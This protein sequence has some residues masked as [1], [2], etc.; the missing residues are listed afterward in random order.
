[1][2]QS[3]RLDSGTATATA[4]A[5]VAA[6]LEQLLGHPVAAWPGQGWTC[7]KQRTVRSVFRGDLDGV[8]VHIKL[9]RADKLSD[10]A[11][12]SLRGQ[13]GQ[14]EC[15]HLLQARA[16][17][18]PAAEPLAF[19]M[20]A[21]DEGLRSFVIT[22]TIADSAPFDFAM[23]AA[24]HDRVGRLLRRLHDLGAEASDLHPGNLLVD[25]HGQPWLID[26][27]AFRHSGEPK[28]SR[29]AHGLSIFCQHLDGGAIDRRARHLL[30][31]YRNGAQVPLPHQLEAQLEL[32]TRR[33]RADAL[34]AFG[35]RSTR[36]C[37]HTEVEPRRRG[38]PRWCWHLPGID[39]AVRDRCHQA[40]ASPPDATKSG[41]RGGVWQL[42]ELIMKRR[43]RGAAKKL[44]RAAYWLLFAGVDTARPVAMC[45]Q[46]GAGHVF[47]ARIDNVPLDRE[48]QQGAM[49]PTAITACARAL[50]RSIGRLHAHGL[51]NRDLKFDNL[52]RLPGSDRVAMVDLDG[53]RRKAAIDSRGSGADLGRLLAAFRQA[54]S[55]GGDATKRAFLRGWLRSHRDLLQR[56]PW[57]RVLRRAEQ[58][59]GE[60]FAS[61]R[62]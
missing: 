12:D 8:P 45:L 60:W 19:G 36:N 61:H 1:M 34:P 55:P 17:G 28:V 4:C 49:S 40:L 7:I 62:D 48:L 30:E 57:R 5:V 27:T 54:G 43:D 50:G 21:D 32:A 31:A 29:R 47:A 6:G 24:V 58:R 53:V 56:P 16:L 59:A 37:R 38:Q 18:L 15:Q 20:A 13:R 52:V 42:E 51:R 10:R 14:R 3:T 35:R 46:P 41:R 22:R 25:G 44:W 33:W 26:L 9:F 39:P 2:P 23:A 11:R